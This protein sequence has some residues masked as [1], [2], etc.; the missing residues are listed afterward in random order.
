MGLPERTQSVL[1]PLIFSNPLLKCPNLDFHD[2]NQGSN[3][4]PRSLSQKPLSS[5]HKDDSQSLPELDWDLGDS[6]EYLRRQ[7]DSRRLLSG[8]G[9]ARR[10]DDAVLLGVA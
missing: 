6:H 8:S 5:L 1:T 7:E 3:I 10:K 4:L 9:S 2:E